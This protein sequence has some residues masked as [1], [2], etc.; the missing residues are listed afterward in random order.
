M[1]EFVS[2]L[3]GGGYI[4][5]PFRILLQIGLDFVLDVSVTNKLIRNTNDVAE[6]S[7]SDLSLLSRKLDGIDKKGTLGAQR[8]LLWKNR[9][10]PGPGWL[11]LK[12][13]L[14]GWGPPCRGS[15]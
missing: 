6:I 9:L 8:L 10:K 7:L 4:C 12:E 5:L 14:G 3:E 11:F 1:V 2:L 13:L 15:R